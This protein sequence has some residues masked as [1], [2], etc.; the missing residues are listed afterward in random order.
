VLR[1]DDE[2]LNDFEGVELSLAVDETGHKTCVEPL[3]GQA[4]LFPKALALA[5]Q[6]RFQPYVLDGKTVPVL[7]DLRVDVHWANPRPTVH[8]PFPAIR[9]RSTLRMGFETSPGFMGCFSYTVEI[10]GDGTLTFDG[11]YGGAGRERT[12]FPVAPEVVEALLERFRKAEFFW[13]H[14]TYSG[15][16]QDTSNFWVSI[17]FDGHK[18]RVADNM[19]REASMPPE[20]EAIEREIERLADARRR[21]FSVQCRPAWRTK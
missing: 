5:K 3:F 21:M 12:T 16:T 7:F 1:V 20:V 18:K 13:L 15:V 8:V 17:E 9:D 19:G 2:T 10:A 11:D 6:W 4:P 14:D